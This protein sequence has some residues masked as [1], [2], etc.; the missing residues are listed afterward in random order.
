MIVVALEKEL[1]AERRA[2]DGGARVVE[3]D[4]YGALTIQTEGA[5]ARR[6]SATS[7]VPGKV[8]D[9]V[10]PVVRRERKRRGGTTLRALGRARGGVVVQTHAMVGRVAA[11]RL[12]RPA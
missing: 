8:I 4:V 12:A 10:S 5:G 2:D 1:D 11:G 3:D 9:T 6:A 7:A